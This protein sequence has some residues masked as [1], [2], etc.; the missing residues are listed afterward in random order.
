MMSQVL[1]SARQAVCSWGGGFEFRPTF[2]E[3]VEACECL[4]RDRK[5]KSGVIIFLLSNKLLHIYFNSA[6]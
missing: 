1:V 6:T 2:A 3:V 5:A 4:G